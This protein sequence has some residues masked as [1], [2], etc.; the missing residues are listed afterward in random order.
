MKYS[1]TT[2]LAAAI[3]LGFASSALAAVP[4]TFT[5]GSPALA[6]E[7]NA[8]FSNLDSRATDNANGIT[9]L[10]GD[11]G[12]LTTRVAALEANDGGSDPYQFVAIN[13]AD[14]PAAL[15][16]ALEAT[17]NTTTRFSYTISGACDAI[18][19]VRNDVKIV[20]QSG[21][22]IGYF[23]QVDYESIYV[24]AQSN[25][26]LENL[27]LEGG[28]SAKNSSSIRLNDVA[29]SPAF[30]DSSGEIIFNIYMK[31]AYLRIDSGSIDHVSLRANRN[32]SIDIKSDVIGLAPQAIVDGN[33][34]LMI[35]SANVSFGVIEAISNSFINADQLVAEELISEGSSMV[36][37]ESLTLSDRLEAWGNARVAVWGDA[38]IEN[39][40][41]VLK[42]SSL[43][44]DGNFTSGTLK[45]QFASSMEFLGDVMTTKT[46]SW[47]DTTSLDVH[48]GCFAQVEGNYSFNA[49]GV[50]GPLSSFIDSGWS[51]ISL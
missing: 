6:S 17:R 27:T 37:A 47:D 51:D 38:T 23:D 45:C 3:G 41:E 42:N 25:V 2:L 5:S 7:V 48:K 49:G 13:C 35:N 24:D 44:V 21:A 14:K 11:V 9:T 40:A 46:F 32:S 34:S 39:D 31:N 8:N 22:S 26:R 19:I 36:E 30:T 20:G 4:N 43:V 16:E 18:E 10:E 12:T 15:A 29:F 33:S 28:L 1:N 50:I